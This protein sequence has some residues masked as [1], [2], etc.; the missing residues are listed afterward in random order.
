MANPKSY[1][2]A[3]QKESTTGT[4]NTTTMQEL[5]AD[6]YPAIG[7][8]FVM[9]NDLRQGVGSIAKTIDLMECKKGALR[10]YQ[11]NGIADTTTLPFLIENAMTIAV[12]TSP[13]SYDFPYN[14]TSPSIS[15]GDTPSDYTKT[16]TLALV[17][18]S[19]SDKAII[20]PGCVCTQLV[21]SASG[22][23]EENGRVKFSATIQSRYKETRSTTTPSSRAAYTNAFYYISQFTTTKT[24]ADAASCEI[25]GFTLTIDNPAIFNGFQGS[26]GD[27]E[28]IERGVPEAVVTSTITVKHDDTSDAI[29]E[30]YADNDSGKV[31]ELSNNATW[32]SATGFGWKGSYA[33]VI[34][35]PQPNEKSSM[36]YDVKQK[37]LAST[38][39]DAIQII[40]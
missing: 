22:I 1:V 19:L 9:M 20:Q 26:D 14:Y 29:I 37:Y 12:S 5:N 36:Y 24:V 35:E 18:T 13:A 33:P 16:F 31:T 11:V 7:S 25:G 15:H 3:I 8:E 39:G 2:V 23:D 27:P 38:S 28:S 32:A 6:A 34:E 4:A 40:A 10:S 17:P 30:N 21:I